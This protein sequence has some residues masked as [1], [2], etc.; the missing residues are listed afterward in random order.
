MN[1][2]ELSAKISVDDSGFKKSMENAQKVSKNVAT[3][4]KQLQSPLDKAKSGF[5]A[6]AH[7]V[8]T[9]KAN[10]EKLKNATV[11][12]DITNLRILSNFI[13]KF[14]KNGRDSNLW[15]GESTLTVKE[16][17]TVFNFQS[18]LMVLS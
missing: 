3:A 18:L 9:A 17:F 14:S 12:Y 8:E 13:S 11:D 10:I 4:I 2:F 5:N 15:N 1:L 7:P 6:I 16:N